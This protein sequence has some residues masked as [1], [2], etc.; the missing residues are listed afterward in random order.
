MLQRNQEYKK[1]YSKYLLSLPDDVRQRLEK[2][3][4]DKQTTKKKSPSLPSLSA[5]SPVL[6]T[7]SSFRVMSVLVNFY[8]NIF[9]VG[10]RVIGLP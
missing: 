9:G 2:E 4:V 10:K 7:C 1:A 8:A 5:P 6:A 3:D